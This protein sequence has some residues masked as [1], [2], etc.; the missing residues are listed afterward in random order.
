M[1]CFTWHNDD[2]SVTREYKVCTVAEATAYFQ[3]S[4]GAH[5]VGSSWRT[6][7]WGELPSGVRAQAQRTRFA[8]YKT[9]KH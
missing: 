3:A 9:H 1:Y 6:A 7:T 5:G 2:G 8:A 4:R